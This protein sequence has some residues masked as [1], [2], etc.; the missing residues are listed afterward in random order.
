MGFSAAFFGTAA[1]STAA[2]TTGL[3][4]AGG[5]FAFAQAIP[6]A[7][8]IGSTLFS[9]AGAAQQAQ[10]AQDQANFQ[11]AVQRNNQIIANRKAG[12]IEKQGKLDAAQQRLRVRQLQGRQLVGLA[13]QGG[14]VT[15]EGD[16][17]LLAET[18]QLGELDAQTIESNAN[19]KAS[20][21]RSQATNFGNQATLFQSKADA[22][23]PGL[24][25]GGTLLSGF[26]KIS[27]QW[28]KNSGGGGGGGNS[29][30]FQAPDF[31]TA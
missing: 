20:A 25:A 12:A 14:D 24:A 16:V 9:G 2:A 13:A 11:A 8:S 30:S 3:I 10:A 21:V 28:Y 18:A 1:T 5:S 17:N 19:R 6:T 27:S 15:A 23:S 4:G 26:G 29:G 22:Q 7:F 31:L